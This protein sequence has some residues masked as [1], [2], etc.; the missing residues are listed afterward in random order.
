MVENPVLSRRDF[1]K[2]ILTY[3]LIALGWGY[4]IKWYSKYVEPFW[5]ESSVFSINDSIIPKSFHQSRIV[6]FSDTHLGF[7]FSIR[8]LKKTVKTINSLQ[9]DLIIF[10]GDLMDEPGS[11]KKSQHIIP[12]LRSLKA[13]YG[14][15]AIYGNHDHGSNGTIL[16]RDIMEASQFKVLRNENM[17]IT[18]KAGESIY[19]AG[20]DEPMIGTPDWYKTLRH[21]PS[22]QFCLLLSHAP[23]LADSA[24]KK[25]VH[26][27]LSGHSHGGQIQIPFAGPLITPPYAKKYY[28]GSYM[29]NSMK[30]FVNRGLG[31]TRIPYRFFSRPEV[32]SITLLSY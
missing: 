28:E 12:V 1:I 11:F 16:F 13:T 32:T 7:H 27:Q 29:V 15:I 20:I 31:T 6:Q 5:L 19:I 14:K 3:I 25:G 18:S 24:S 4:G 30:L 9:P 2:K 10:T 26:A 23:D 21:I 17:A 22:D 8:Q